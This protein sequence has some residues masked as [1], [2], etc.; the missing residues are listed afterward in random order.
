MNL[1]EEKEIVEIP[2]PEK[3]PDHVPAEPVKAPEPK[4]PVPG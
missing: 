2:H 3:I 1:G 4:V